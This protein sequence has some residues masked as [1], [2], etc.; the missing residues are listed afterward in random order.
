MA[1]PKFKYAWVRRYIRRIEDYLIKAPIDATED[2]IA[3]FAEL[4]VCCSKYPQSQ[5][6]TDLTV[7]YDKPATDKEI[8][9]F[10]GEATVMP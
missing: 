2:D 7:S 1:K 3:L 9:Y 6:T 8:K 4:H 10:K 5:E